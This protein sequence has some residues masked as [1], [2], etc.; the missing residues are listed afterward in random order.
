M[1]VAK[2]PRWRDALRFRL[3]Q[4]ECCADSGLFVCSI[5]V[6]NEPITSLSTVGTM[7]SREDE[8]VVILGKV[9][10]FPACRAGASTGFRR[11]LRW[12]PVT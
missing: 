10:K 9:S 2:S 5:C 7:R 11:G 4:E 8:G 12:Q 3:R 6:Y 1:T